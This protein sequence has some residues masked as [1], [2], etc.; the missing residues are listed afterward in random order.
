MKKLFTLLLFLSISIITFTS[1]AQTDC[2]PATITKVEPEGT[3]NRIN[4][5]LPPSGEEVLISQ[6][7]DSKGLPS[8]FYEWSLGVYH[9]FTPEHLATINGGILTQIVFV[10]S[11]RITQTEPGHTYTIQV[12]SGGV[13]GAD[14]DRNPGTL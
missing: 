5:T 9:R 14:S 13:W 11:Y 4:W 2:N 3:G 12:Y 10:P 6:N 8:G 1:Y 7:E